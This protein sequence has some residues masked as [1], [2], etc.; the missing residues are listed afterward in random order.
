MQPKLTRGSALETGTADEAGS[1][2][3]RM[4]KVKLEEGGKAVE[5]GNE[6]LE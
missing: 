4:L 5:S 3:E 6:D 2:T 1:D